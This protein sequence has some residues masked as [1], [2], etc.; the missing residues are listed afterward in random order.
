MTAPALSPPLDQI[1][2]AL[3]GLLRGTGRDVWDG[4]YGGDPTQPAY[5]YGILYRIPGGSSDATPD[6][7]G[8]PR[9]QTVPYQVTTV[10][11]LRN[12][13]EHTARLFRDRLLA[14]APGGFLHPLP[15]LDG[16]ACVDR[17]PDPAMP[18]IDRAGD[19][20]TAVFSPA[21]PLPAHHHPSLRS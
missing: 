15:T 10:S 11:N 8:T 7:S 1:T 18:G 3:L 20:P 12:Q 4:A 5:P 13:C 2:T 19:H 16:W 14:R 21:R 17:R 9:T 6:L